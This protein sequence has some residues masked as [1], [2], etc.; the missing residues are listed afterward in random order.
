MGKTN[1]DKIRIQLDLT[2]QQTATVDQLE[3]DT[4]A[5]TRAEVLRRAISF[6]AILIAE[7]KKGHNLVMTNADGTHIRELIIL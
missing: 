4:E 1:D 5:S 7:K 3:V 6:Y 2:P